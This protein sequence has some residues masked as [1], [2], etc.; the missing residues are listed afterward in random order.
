MFMMIFVNDL[1]GAGKIVPDWMV[2]FSDRHRGGSGMTFV[3]LVFPAFLFIV[4]MSVPFALGRR[5]SKG[6]PLWRTLLHIVAR[7]LSLLF[8]GLLMVNESPNAETLGWSPELWSTLMYLSAIVAFCSVS[9]TRTS[10]PNVG[11]AQAFRVVS[12]ILRVAGFASLVWLSFAWR[13]ENDRRIITLSPFSIHTDWFGILGLI[14]WAYLVAAVAFLLF[15]DNRTALLGCM[16]LLLCLYPADKSHAFDH[17]WPARY[18]GIGDMLGSLAAIS[19][20]GLLLSSILVGA[21]KVASGARIRF[22]LLFIGGTAAAGWLLDGLYGISKN[23]ATPSWCLWACAITAALWLLAYFISDVFSMGFLVRPFAVA[24]QN[25]LLAYLLS[26]M[27]PSTLNLFNLDGW[28]V[29]LAGP[30]LIHAV[31][32]SATCGAVILCATAGL[33]RLGLRLRL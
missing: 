16:A 25:V 3:D 31:V 30:D 18:V 24:G 14:A 17:F 21:D 10:G 27:L 8:I 23:A 11:R 9:P 29:R 22:A 5:V 33:N 19:V 12:T 4:G 7:T 15:R 6:E 26:E 20:G 32:R 1:A 13:G 2:H 28:Y